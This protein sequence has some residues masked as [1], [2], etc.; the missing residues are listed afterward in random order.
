MLRSVQRGCA[1]RPGRPGTFFQALPF[2][3][4]CIC[5]SFK[6]I[7]QVP[8]LVSKLACMCCRYMPAYKAYLPGLYRN[9][10]KAKAQGGPLLVVEVDKIRGLARQQPQPNRQIVNAACLLL[11]VIFLW[12]QLSV[13]A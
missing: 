2:C 13:S 6:H 4:S 9:G 7:Q 1:A 12:S 5:C 10:P 3:K 11:T 8:L